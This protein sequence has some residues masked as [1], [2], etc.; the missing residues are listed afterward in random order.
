MYYLIQK[1]LDIHVRQRYF[2]PP[3]YRWGN[4]LTKVK[5]MSEGIELVRVRGW[6]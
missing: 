6:A 3:F 2:S 1:L 5:N 4:S